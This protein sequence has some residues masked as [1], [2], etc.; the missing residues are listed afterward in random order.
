MAGV[1]YSASKD[2]LGGTVQGEAIAT[3]ENGRVYAASAG[4]LGVTGSGR[5]IGRYDGGYIYDMQGGFGS[6]GGNCI[7]VYKNNEIFKNTSCQSW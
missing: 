3:F 6:S 5:Q 4:F 7:A 1:L 2:S